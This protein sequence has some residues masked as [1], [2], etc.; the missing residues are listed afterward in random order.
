MHASVKGVESRGPLLELIAT[1]EVEVDGSH[2]L[3]ML[4]FR[5]S[6]VL[7]AVYLGDSADLQPS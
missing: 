4:V 3:A 1:L 5:H 6:P 7:A 2:A